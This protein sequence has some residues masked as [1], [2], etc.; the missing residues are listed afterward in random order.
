[1]VIASFIT[2]PPTSLSDSRRLCDLADCGDG[3]LRTYD[4]DQAFLLPPDLKAWL[5]EDDLAYFAIAA[6]ERVP[7][8]AF[9]VNPRPAIG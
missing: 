7:L 8:G 1:L 5:P 6:V 9:A 2:A 4:R 3:D